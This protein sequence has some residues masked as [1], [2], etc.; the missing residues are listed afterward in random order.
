MR[1]MAKTA[2]TTSRVFSKAERDPA[3]PVSVTKRRQTRLG[4]K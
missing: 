2:R 4:C 1:L 3:Y